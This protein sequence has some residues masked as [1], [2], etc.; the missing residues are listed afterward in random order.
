MKGDDQHVWH[1]IIITITT[2]EVT[3]ASGLGNRG[4]GK[5][6]TVKA[7]SQAPA[8]RPSVRAGTQPISCETKKCAY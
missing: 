4:G 2:S 7:K 8:V 6:A 3:R 5:G 1:S